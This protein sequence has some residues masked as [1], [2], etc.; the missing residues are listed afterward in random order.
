MAVGAAVALFFLYALVIVVIDVI[1]EWSKPRTKI[2]DKVAWYGDIGDRVG[3]K[4]FVPFGMLVGWLIEAGLLHEDF[5]IDEEVEAEIKRFKSRS[6][7]GPQLYELWDG[8]LDDDMLTEEGNHFLAWYTGRFYGD[9]ADT[10]CDGAKEFDESCFQVED[11][12]ENYERLKKVIDGRFQF[13]KNE[14]SPKVDET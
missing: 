5:C 6:L 11:T 8:V 9:F 3:D 7:T 14:V 13:W 12:W 4:A 10:L 2:Y 1:A